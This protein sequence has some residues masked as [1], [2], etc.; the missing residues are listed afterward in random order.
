[1]RRRCRGQRKFLIQPRMKGGSGPLFQ[2]ATKSVCV[3][4]Q[5]QLLGREQPPLSYIYID[6]AARDIIVLVASGPVTA[7]T[8]ACGWTYSVNGGVDTAPASA[9]ISQ[10][11]LELTMNAP[12]AYGDVVTISYDATGCDLAVGGVPVESD[13]DREVNNNIAEPVTPIFSGTI[14]DIS[15][16]VDEA[17]TPYDASVHFT[18]GGDVAT[19]TL[20]N[21]PTG[22][23]IDSGTGIISGTPTV[24]AVTPGLTV[25]GTNDAGSDVSNAFQ[26]SVV[27][28]W[29]EA[30]I[31]T[32][33]TTGADELITFP[34]NATNNDFTVDWDYPNG[35][36][37][38]ITTSNPTHTYAVAGDYDISVHGIMP[39]FNQR[40]TPDDLK[41]VELKQ[42]GDTSFERLIDFLEN[43]SN[44]VVT[45]T[46]S[47]NTSGVV[48]MTRAFR[49]ASLVNFDL[50]AWDVSLV[51]GAL[52]FMLDTSLSTINYDALLISWGAQ[53][54]LSGVD[55]N[56][57]PTTYT[58]GGAAEAGR[59]DLIAAGWTITDGGPAA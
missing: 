17:M 47:A 20:Q 30:F 10:N 50:S 24:E 9:S 1:M 58:A 46:D 51:T 13:T 7:T 5:G 14:A 2:K 54:V 21:A 27:D 38:V 57:S 37:E 26:M 39:R 19:Y 43:A 49:N 18:T 29:A 23:V 25:T 45:A 4:T 15:T 35:V 36:T 41:W 42:W 8:P 56:F 55:I 16:P 28:P 6:D 12:A 52:N 44:A 31:I 48:D 22:V 40:Q 53:S 34:A 3:H 11:V 33:R 32:V 59:D